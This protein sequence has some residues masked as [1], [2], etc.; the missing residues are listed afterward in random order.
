MY[1]QVY[2]RLL[3]A[4]TISLGLGVKADCVLRVTECQQTDVSIVRPDPLAFLFTILSMR[5]VIEYTVT[6]LAHPCPTALSFY[7]SIIFDILWSNVT[8]V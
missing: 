7:N 6:V 1:N 2:E 8:E 5:N 4:P 3:H